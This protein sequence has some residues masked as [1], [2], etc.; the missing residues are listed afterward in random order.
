MRSDEGEKESEEHGTERE[1]VEQ[2]KGR[3]SVC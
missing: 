2:A 3:E 1:R